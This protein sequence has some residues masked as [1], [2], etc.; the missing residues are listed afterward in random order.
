MFLFSRSALLAI[1]AHKWERER[2]REKAGSE[3]VII[4]IIWKIWRPL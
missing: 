4:C 2:E 1:I 3:K